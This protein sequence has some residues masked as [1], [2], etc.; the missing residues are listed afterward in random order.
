MACQSQSKEELE[1]EKMQNSQYKE[2]LMVGS[3]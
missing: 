3:F 2:D 1:N